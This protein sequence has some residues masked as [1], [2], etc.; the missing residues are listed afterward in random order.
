MRSEPRATLE[1]EG[2]QLACC[3]SVVFVLR[4]CSLLCFLRCLGK[5]PQ[6]G[7]HES[8]RVKYL[9]RDQ[10]S[11]LHLQFGKNNMCVC[12][13]AVTRAIVK[14]RAPSGIPLKRQAS[15]GSGVAPKARLETGVFVQAKGTL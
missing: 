4:V 7:S 5:V 3:C 13:L 8:P 6:L 10:A 9:Y 14:F 15:P 2:V 1:G 12:V 11:S